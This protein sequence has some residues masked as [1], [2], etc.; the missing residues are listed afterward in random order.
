MRTTT[1]TLTALA[2]A[3]C[4]PESFGQTVTFQQGVAG[5][6]SVFDINISFS[7]PDTTLLGS[8]N[9]KF[10]VNGLAGHPAD[11]ATERQM[12]I[13]FDDILGGAAGQVPFGA[14]ITSAMLSLTTSENGGGGLE[15]TSGPHAIAKLLVPFDASTSWNLLGGD[16]AS[17]D[18][19]EISRPLVNGIGNASFGEV[20]DLDVTSIVQDWA[21]GGPN[22]GVLL[23]PG[24]NDLWGLETS[25]S[26]TAISRPKLT[27]T[28]DP[29][30][31]PSPVTQTAMLRQGLAGYAGMT[32]VGFSNDVTQGTNDTTAD[33]GD[34]L[35]NDGPNFSDTA[36]LRFEQIFASE[37]GLV[38]D[39]ANIVSAKLLITGSR[40]F[41]DADPGNT[42]GN[43]AP[44]KSFINVHQMLQDWGT[45]T[46]WDAAFGSLADPVV[47]ADISTVLGSANNIVED[48]QMVV[49]VTSALLD[50]QSGSTNNGFLVW[51]GGGDG[52]RMALAGYGEVDGRPTLIVE[53]AAVPEPSTAL[54]VAAGLLGFLAA[55]RHG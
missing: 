36:L 49:D 50:W 3:M 53:Y 21:D 30:P 19:G 35:D 4:M 47:G 27:V 7:Q 26:A 46:T 13:R 42:S 52:W 2:V 41:S 31:A 16:G 32:S 51:P 29:N 28:F 55:R 14:Q 48:A 11:I 8:S 15:S 6:N 20:A 40:A 1:F 5:Y 24:R 45:T 34:W 43:G 25:S 33:P 12:L 44:T 38:P 22:Y 18:D 23:R 17:L 9:S 37:G 39:N 10:F 54:L